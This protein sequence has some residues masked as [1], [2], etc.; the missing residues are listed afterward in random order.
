MNSV[1]NIIAVL[2]ILQLLLAGCE[3]RKCCP[4]DIQSQGIV[5]AGAELELVAD[6]FG[7]T[8][9]PAVDREG[10]VYFTDQPNDRIMVYYT[11]GRLETILQPSGRANGMYFDN[12]GFLLACADLAGEIWKIDLATKEHTVLVGEYGGVRFNATNDIWV[13]PKGGI[14]F[15]D[16]YYQRRWWSHS[17]LPQDGEHV[18]CLQPDSGKLTRVADDLK[19]P[20]GLIGTPDG[21]TLYIS[22]ID[23]GRIFQYYITKDG[24][25]ANKRIFCEMGSDGMTIDCCGNIYLANAQ[26]VTVCDKDG[27]QLENIKV[28]ANWTA[29]L[30]FAGPD[31]NYLFITAQNAIYRIK[32]NVCGCGR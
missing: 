19:K 9:G 31:R 2:I 28:P 10:N 17:G 15:T 18:Y 4:V 16:P 3:V 22:D 8:E 32:T 14:Y 23:A 24:S 26:G 13:S 29:N 12:D 21:K 27:N 25:L 7:F 20:N 5:A 11:D 1:L 6:G 30:T